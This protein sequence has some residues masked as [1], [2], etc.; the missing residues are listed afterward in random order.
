M[1]PLLGQECAKS[2]QSCPTFCDSMDCSPRGFSVRGIL[3]ARILEWV[4]ISFSRGSSW[5]RDW[6]QVSCIADR[7]FTIWATR[8]ARL[9]KEEGF[10]EETVIPKKQ[11]SRAPSWLV[12]HNTSGMCL[13]AAHPLPR[14]GAWAWCRKW[15]GLEMS[16]TYAK[17]LNRA[18]QGHLL[19]HRKPRHLRIHHDFARWF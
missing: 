2:L 4:A 14:R 13:L 18:H 12:S 17:S 7:F 9:P 3:Q 16:K 10:S 19:F 15:E 11:P 5:S 6:T 8:E 1:Y